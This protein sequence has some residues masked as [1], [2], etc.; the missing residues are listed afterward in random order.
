MK[1]LLF[2]FCV[3]LLI[4]SCNDQ[5]TTSEMNATETPVSSRPHKILVHLQ[6]FNDFTAKEAEVVKHELNEHLLEMGFDSQVIDI[7]PAKRLDKSF[8]NEYKTRYSAQKIVNSLKKGKKSEVYIG[9]LHEDVSLPLRGK[10]DWGVRGLSSLNQ[11]ASVVSTYRI[12]NQ[13]QDMWKTV[14]HEFGHAFAGINHCTKDKNC[15]MRDANGK[16]WSAD[17][18][19]FCNSCTEAMLAA[20][21]TNIVGNGHK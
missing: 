1:H 17:Q 8:L 2:F 19:G 13:K 9:L 6:P 7:L 20:Q 14:L 15:L 11:N 18:R 12:R 10:K 5:K 3:G 4:M 21:S 16:G